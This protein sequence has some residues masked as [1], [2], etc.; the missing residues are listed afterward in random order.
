MAGQRQRAARMASRGRRAVDLTRAR[1]Q[2]G[3]CQVHEGGPRSAWGQAFSRSHRTCS[4]ANSALVR[5][6]REPPV[7]PQQ[8][9]DCRARGSQP[10]GW[11]WQV[12]GPGPSRPQAVRR[13]KPGSGERSTTSARVASSARVSPVSRAWS[14]PLAGNGRWGRRYPLGPRQTSR[15][16]SEW[17]GVQHGKTIG[18]PQPSPRLGCSAPLYADQGS[19]GR[20]GGLVF[21]MPIQGHEEYQSTD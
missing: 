6:G 9:A 7:S 8:V 3:V 11:R 10:P 12:G 2:R 20:T 5:S 19:G 1:V 4:A 17:P 14:C 15:S 16:P 13:G 18:G 21:E